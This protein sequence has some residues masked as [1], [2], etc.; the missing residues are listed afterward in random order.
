MKNGHSSGRLGSEDETILAS[1]RAVLADH[2][3]ASKRELVLPRETS[4]AMS[5][6]SD[7]AAS[8]VDLARFGLRIVRAMQSSAARGRDD[9]ARGKGIA[10]P[11]RPRKP[12]QSWRAQAASG[13]CWSC[14]HRSSASAVSNCSGGARAAAGQLTGATRRCYRSHQHGDRFRS[15]APSPRAARAASRCAEGAHPA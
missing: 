5:G 10:R 9:C 11:E 2:V 6:G 1:Y 13:A 8:D 15:D 4:S 7:S 14:G 12:K 3:P